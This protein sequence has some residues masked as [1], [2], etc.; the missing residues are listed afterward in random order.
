MKMGTR[1]TAGS[2][3]PAAVPQ[4]MRD[5][6]ASI[7]FHALT[8]TGPHPGWTLTWLEGRPVAEL[9]T[10]VMVVIDPATGEA[11]VQRDPDVDVS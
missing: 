5:A 10:G 3:P 2:T 9:D 1:W 6:I 7:E 11:V 4:A 8:D